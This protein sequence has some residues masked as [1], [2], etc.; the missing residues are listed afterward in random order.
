MNTYN[1]LETQS[2]R[3]SNVLNV[4]NGNYK[5][6]GIL[7]K[8]LSNRAVNPEEA[9]KARADAMYFFRYAELFNTSPQSLQR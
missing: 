2:K 1:Y 6:A 4:T 5:K 3:R 8:R 7:L 9:R